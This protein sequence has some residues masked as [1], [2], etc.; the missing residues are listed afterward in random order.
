[1]SPF[2][3][4]FLKR[5][6]FHIC[7]LHEDF[8]II[9]KVSVKDPRKAFKMSERKVCIMQKRGSGFVDEAVEEIYSLLSQVHAGI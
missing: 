4:L 7:I 6:H 2:G 5:T 8:S 1:M 9:R 3:M